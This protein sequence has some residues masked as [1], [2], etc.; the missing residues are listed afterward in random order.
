MLKPEFEMSDDLAVVSKCSRNCM[1]L[2]VD[3]FE[4]ESLPRSCNP[5]SSKGVTAT[6]ESAGHFHAACSQGGGQLGNS[7][8]C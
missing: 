6:K 4:A 1:A 3:G 7:Q 5:M 2:W 8:N